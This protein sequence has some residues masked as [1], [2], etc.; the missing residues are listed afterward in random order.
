M[1]PDTRWQRIDVSQAKALLQRADTTVFD[2]RD[3]NSF[4]QSHIQGAYYLSNANLE[5]A[6]LKTPK[7]KPVLIYC[8]HGNA[9]QT[10]A[11]IFVDFGFQEVY[12]LIGGYETWRV[13][14]SAAEPELC[15][16]EAG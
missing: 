1:N 2:M 16:Q 7:D 10:G 3:E 14:E 9:S 12:D 15:L 5:Q 11:A 8:Y 13:A 4:G 6:I